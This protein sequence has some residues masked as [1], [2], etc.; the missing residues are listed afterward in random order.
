MTKVLL[1][2]GILLILVDLYEHLWLSRGRRPADQ[3][4][5]GHLFRLFG[6]RIYKA[7]LG[8]ILAILGLLLR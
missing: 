5:D 4:S 6:I 3:A 7:Y 8:V 1:T 2:L